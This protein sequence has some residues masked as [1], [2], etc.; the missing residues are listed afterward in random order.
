MTSCSGRQYN[1]DNL[2]DF[3]DEIF[4]KHDMVSTLDTD[5]KTSRQRNKCLED[6]KTFVNMWRFQAGLDVI[7]TELQLDTL[8]GAEIIEDYQSPYE[9]PEEYRGKAIK[10]DKAHEDTWIYG[11][12]KGAEKKINGFLHLEKHIKR[13]LNTIHFGEKRQGVKNHLNLLVLE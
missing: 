9:V 3:L 5:G 2:Y 13:C 8:S 6:L 12:V 4:K 10:G 1:G 11:W 7:A